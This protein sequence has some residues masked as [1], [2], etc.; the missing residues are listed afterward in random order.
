MINEQDLRF[1]ALIHFLVVVVDL[2]YGS[3]TLEEELNSYLIKG[4][5]ISLRYPKEAYS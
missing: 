2:D 3:F 1:V 4:M 5:N